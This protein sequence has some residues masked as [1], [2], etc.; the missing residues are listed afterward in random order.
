MD[1]SSG[2]GGGLKLNKV[3]LKP[4][5]NSANNSQSAATAQQSRFGVTEKLY[6]NDPEDL[7]SIS[8]GVPADRNSVIEYSRTLDLLIAGQVKALAGLENGGGGGGGGQQTL[9]TS[10]TETQ[11]V[12]PSRGGLNA[13]NS[14]KQLADRVHQLRKM[15]LAVSEEALTPQQ[16]FRIRELL[17]KLE[18]NSDRLRSSGGQQQVTDGQLVGLYG[19]LQANIRDIITVV[20]K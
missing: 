4:V 16:R 9:Q 18:K 17:T 1:S 3:V 15:C 2:G 6:A 19:D 8:P 14:N 7:P 10:T 5:G 12:S 11:Q 20:Q 13:S